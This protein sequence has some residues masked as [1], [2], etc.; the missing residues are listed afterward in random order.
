MWSIGRGL[1]RRPEVMVAVGMSYSVMRWIFCY[2]C[3]YTFSVL[4]GS[5]GRSSGAM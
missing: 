5:D 4:C 2:V 1:M 3:W